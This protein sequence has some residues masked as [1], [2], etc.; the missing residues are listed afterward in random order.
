MTPEQRQREL[1]RAIVKWYE[2]EKESRVAC[3]VFE[4]GNSVLI[5]DALEEKG[6]RVSR[7]PLAGSDS[8]KESGD[9]AHNGAACGD[10]E[11]AGGRYDE[12]IYDIVIA[13]DVIEY[14]SDAAD[15]L[16]RIRR[17][18][19]PDGKLLLAADN[20]LGIRYFCGDQDAFSGRN[21]DSI[22]NYRH[23]RS[24]ERE[25]MKGRAYSRAEL[26]GFLEKAGFSQH[27]FFSIFPRISNPQLL[28]AEDYVP[29]EAL[30]IRVFPE[31]NNPDT[32][33]LMEEELYPSL[34][35]NG[36]L[37]GMANGFFIECPL[38]GAFS[39]IKQITLSGERG[40]QNAMATIIRS[41]G[42]VEKRALYQEGREK[43]RK[44]S[45]NNAYLSS[46]GV[47]MIDAKVEGEAFLMPYVTGTP[48][49]EHFRELLQKN[50]EAF[51]RELDTFWEILQHSSEPVSPDEV[52]W[53]KFEPGWE[54][55]KKDDPNR[56]KWK[57]IAC[58]TEKERKELGI[59]LKRGYLDLV[60][61][62]CFFTEGT[63][64][65]YDQEMFLENVPAKALMVRTI[66]FIY[67][68][69]DQLDGILP[70]RELFERYGMLEHMGLYQKFIGHFLNILREDDGLSDYFKEGRREYEAVMENRRRMNYSEEEY[71][72]IFKD[73]F[74]QTKGRRLYL[75]GSGRYAERFLEKYGS[76]YPVNGYLDN[77]EK[78]WGTE[79]N[80]LPVLAP[81]ALKEMNPAEYKVII[82]IKNY[83]PVVNQL[84]RAGI[85]NYS[86]FDPKESYREDSGAENGQRAAAGWQAAQGKTSKE[87]EDK[88]YNIGYVAGV[89]DLFHIGHLNLLRRAK[90]Q[91][92]YLIVGV[93][94]DE[95]VIRH[96]KSNP[97]I[98]YEERI[99]IVRACKYVDE[100][101]EI[102]LDRG[103]TDE[104]WRRYRFDAQFSGSDY[105]DD[106]KWMAKKDFLQRHGSDL[107]FFPYTEGISTTQLKDV[108]ND[109]KR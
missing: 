64:V 59:I 97:R 62:N 15:T 20:R 19:Q 70:R 18:L 96:K 87:R 7:I 50:R 63:F 48:A 102:P 54:K 2:I 37:H 72:M 80:G 23:L 33:F 89:F 86:V 3:I 22:E 100:A 104:A 56:D 39:P 101:V 17:L 29:N 32:V 84:H 95:G 98:P 1:P 44:L 28:L 46:H 41:D 109:G 106:P 16:C 74:H 81:A 105:A 43:L 66:E 92:N 31:Y 5:A 83:M 55:R 85:P 78:R 108:V 65:F 21:Y 26:I 34:M 9:K 79:V 11:C 24:W 35:E 38:Q 49:N 103:D 107:V 71:P 58:G 53:E 82:C 6:L 77:D 61:L 57:K 40:F 75:F 12:G 60:S 52:D 47:K 36:L 8:G 93:V 99:A 27:R 73:I 88:K 91:C 13:A 76:R 69:N 68:F 10:A 51:L 14:A 25:A 30:D 42:F 67:K 45:E 4:D 94:T 90:E